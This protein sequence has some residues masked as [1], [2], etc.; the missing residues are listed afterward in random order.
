MATIAWIFVYAG[1]LG[2][3][4]DY[5]L[6]RASWTSAAPRLALRLWHATAVGV[7]L[8][9]GWG[10]ML[11]AHDVM[12][13]GFAW[14]FRAD[15]TRVHLAYAPGVEVPSYW[16]ATIGLIL[17][18]VGAGVVAAVRR[19][20]TERDAAAL[21]DMAVA[22]RLMVTNACG[23]IHRVGMCHSP[24]PLIYCLPTGGHSG[25]IRVTTAAL[26]LLAREELLA[27][28]EH[29]QAHIDCRHHRQLMFA[30]CIIAALRWTRLLRHYPQAVRE[31][32]EYQADDHA[33]KRYGRRTVA[34]AL[35]TMCSAGTDQAA[36]AGASWTGG[37]P[38][39]R[40]KRLLMSRHQRPRTLL[41]GIGIGVV[42]LFPVAP[43]VA[44]IAPALA[45]ANTQTAP[46][47]SHIEA[48]S[49]ASFDHHP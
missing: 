46:V 21:H 9:L 48:P 29:E 34:R 2:W 27:A 16:N 10:M 22:E 24:V 17:V 31:L 23:E 12:E 30:D 13:H 19:A 39:V 40:I 20:R 1:T 32:V 3:L 18:V 7:L 36:P 28:I 6:A 35:L 15:K 33:A 43:C 5:L 14:L 45:L 49:T 37:K 4:G 42:V 26:D 25:R 8:A 11:L 47:T 41:R 38:A 44:A